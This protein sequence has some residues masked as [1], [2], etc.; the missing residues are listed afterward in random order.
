MS[1]NIPMEIDELEHEHSSLFSKRVKASSKNVTIDTGTFLEVE[2]EIS[3]IKNVIDNNKYDQFQIRIVL[4]NIV[5]DIE[6]I[7]NNKSRT[8]QDL[9][10]LYDLIAYFYIYRYIGNDEVI[11]IKDE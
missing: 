6:I 2:A 9:N 11:P 10:A 8:K 5:D 1:N 4:N 3:K 7:L